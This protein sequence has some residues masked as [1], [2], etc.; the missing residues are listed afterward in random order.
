MFVFGSNAAGGYNLTDS[1]RFRASASA[2]LERTP[3]TTGN[4][5]TEGHED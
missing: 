5:K 3:T 4:Q 2:S 1:V